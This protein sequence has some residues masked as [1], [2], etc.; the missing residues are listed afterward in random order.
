MPRRGRSNT[1]ARR[2]KGRPNT[3]GTDLVYSGLIGFVLKQITHYLRMP[4]TVFLQE[5]GRNRVRSEALT[6]W[7]LACNNYSCSLTIKRTVSGLYDA[8]IAG[9]LY[10]KGIGVL[11]YRPPTLRSPRVNEWV[12][13][14]QVTLA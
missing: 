2:Y 9:Y 7:H 10:S 8:N 14:V 12:K 4:L 1:M 5:I 6:V 3:F 13:R 11:V